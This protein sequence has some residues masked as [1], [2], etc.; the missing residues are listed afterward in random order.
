VS[1]FESLDYYELLGVSRAATP[2]EI[3]R[4]YRQEI[5]KYHPDRFANASPAEQD[6]A[7]RRSQRITEAYSTLSDLVART[8]YN[9]GQQPARDRAARRPPAPPQPRDHQAELYRQAREH[10]E[11][12]R[13]LQALGAPRPL[14]QINPFFRDSAELLARTEAQ[15]QARQQRPAPRRS[16]RPLFIV[17]GL[18]GGAMMV[19]IIGLV[20]GITRSANRVGNAAGSPATAVPAVAL[21]TVAPTATLPPPT[22]APVEPS[23]TVVQPTPLPT[24]SPAPVAPTA[25]APAATA[26]VAADAPTPAGETGALLV[27]DRF[28]SGGWANS[29]GAG[30]RVGYQ[31]GRYRVAVDAGYGTI[32]SFRTAPANDYSLGVDVSVTKGEGGLLLRFVDTRNFLSFS[33]NPGQTSYR[34]EQ[35]RGG[36][37]NVLAGG[38]SEAIQAGADATNRLIVHLRGDYVE[39]LANGQL[40]AQLD[41]SGATNSG[42]YGLLAIGGS[43]DA[44]VFFDNLELRA[45]E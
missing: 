43:A 40:L 23:A 28:S 32:W 1:D 41:A 18:A 12:D 42:R 6:Y 24:P 11:A 34:L 44:E 7:S 19:A 29:S 4:A 39:L 13:L 37:V 36:V 8:A 9:R 16:R 5:S 14:Q 30:W 20:V 10:L 15:L 31:N 26:P 27:A 22:A 3:K 2:D 45:L 35:H 17:G 33:I 25:T 21:A 38:Q